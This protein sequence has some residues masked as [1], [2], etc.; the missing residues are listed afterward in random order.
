[1]LFR[2]ADLA[3]IEAGTITLA[4]RRWT[5][6]RAVAGGTQRTPIGVIEITEV[7]RVA[8]PTNKD[9]RAAGYRDAQHV[10]DS[11]VKR[12]GDLYRIALRLAGPDPRIALREQPPDAAVFARLER[13]GEWTY[14]YLQ[15]IHDHPGRRAPDLAA[16]FGRETAPF[17][18]D[19]RKLK[20]LGLT[21][22]LEVG[23]ELSRRGQ[24][25]LS[26]RPNALRK[27]SP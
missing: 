15:A 24:L 26:S 27:T 11:F 5:T 23:Y 1:V 2:P 25:T 7:K 3:G 18:R 20:E 8:K 6:P 21:I 10:L 14:E 16:S 13:M 4:F 12:E 19:V 22:S 9:A 17:K